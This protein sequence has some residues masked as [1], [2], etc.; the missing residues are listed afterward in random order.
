MTRGWR[1]GLSV[2]AAVV[3]LDLGLHFLGTLTGGTPGGPQSS[4]YATGATGLGAYAELLGRRSHGI[5]RLRRTPHALKLDP[6]HTI[7]LLDPPAVT[8]RDARALRAFVTAGGRLIAGGGN[9]GWLVQLVAHPPSGDE[10]G[11]RLA[12]RLGPAFAG[13]RTVR[14]AGDLAWRKT[15]ETRA[16][17]GRRRRIVVADARLGR[18]TLLLL[19]DPS[20][21]QNRLL[22]EADNAALGLA[23]AG[24]PGRSVDFLETYHGYGRSTGLSALPL[25]WKLLLG[26]LGLAALVYLI[27]RGRRLGPPELRSRELPP[28]RSEYVRALAAVVA[29]TRRWDDAVAPVR[30][31]AREALLRRAA[32]PEDSDDVAVV[33]AARRLGIAAD[34]ADALVR[35]ART[36]ADVLAVG[37]ALARI[38]QDRPR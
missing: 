8:T 36:D 22:G 35:P 30:R 21:L 23:L 25:A 1:I 38:G 5:D 32:L 10:N 20:P 9:T 15:G 19:A 24:S 12:H 17:F 34:D 26:G 2:L 27:A 37:R 31:H 18:G 28:P 13:V 7:V 33:A 11:I 14:T 3:A 6:T 29:R 4:S 16:L